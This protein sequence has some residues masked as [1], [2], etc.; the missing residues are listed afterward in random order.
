MTNDPNIKINCSTLFND[1]P[2]TIIYIMTNGC[3]LVPYNGDLSFA[4]HLTLKNIPPPLSMLN[5]LSISAIIFS[6]KLKIKN[7]LFFEKYLFIKLSHFPMFD[8]NFK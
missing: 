8:S 1:S 7:E 2:P 6:K 3:L 4:F 5:D